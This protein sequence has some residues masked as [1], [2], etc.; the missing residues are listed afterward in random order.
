MRN[1]RE[2]QYH[3]GLSLHLPQGTF[4]NCLSFDYLVGCPAPSASTL[5]LGERTGVP[6]RQGAGPEI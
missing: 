3:A 2:W 5:E 1:D 4:H 6:R